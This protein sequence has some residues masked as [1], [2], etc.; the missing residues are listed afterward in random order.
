MLQ[1]QPH[2]DVTFCHQHATHCRKKALQTSDPSLKAEYL[3]LEHRWSCLARSYGL[4]GGISD[5]TNEVH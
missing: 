3:S 1:Q 5:F 4:S 2:D